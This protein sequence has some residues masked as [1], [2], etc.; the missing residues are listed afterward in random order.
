MSFESLIGRAEV[1][2][3]YTKLE[4]YYSGKMSLKALGISLPDNARILEMIANFPQLSV[5]VVS[6]L[7]VPE[8][9][10]LEDDKET[11]ALLR[12]WWNTNNMDA[13]VSQAVTEALVQGACYWIVGYGDDDTPRITAHDRRGMATS[14]N[15]MGELSEAVRTYKHGDDRYAA[16]YLPF[17]T[18]YYAETHYG[19]K[20]VDVV[21]HG[22]DRPLVVPMFNKERLSD[23]RGRS[24]LL[25][26]LDL[27]DAASR[28]LTN[29]QV[30]QETASLPQRYMFGKDMDAM[31]TKPILDETGQPI[32]DP[33]SPTGYRM[34]PMSGPELKVAR[35]ETYWG[36][37]W[38]GP[39]GATAGQLP[40][41]DLT[42]MID[43]YKLYSQAVSAVTGIPPSM[44]AVSGDQ[45]VSAEAMIAAK[46]RL[47][48]RAELKQTL[49]G[50]ALEDVARV[51]LALYDKTPENVSQLGLQWRDPATPSQ[52]ARSAAL[53]QAHAQGVISAQTARDGLRLTPEQ[54]ARED[55]KDAA[56]D[57][58]TALYGGSNDQ[59]EAA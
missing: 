6:E 38:V 30:A 27:T 35:Q 3:A 55:A 8:G 47:N 4:G 34:Q 36:S 51:A 33:K 2:K 23:T 54:R 15:H 28:T 29:L 46:E 58:I 52:N 19:W 44:L 14:Y 21:E 37:L 41:A 45:P 56:A 57:P 59:E 31:F 42:M 24:D 16:H 18:R 17:E 22:L 25:P 13:E 12:S 50:D 53:L 48:R 5:Q 49:F 20:V 9:Y 1:S 39:E 40:G 7:L 10:I 26:I 11:P 43:T 32:R